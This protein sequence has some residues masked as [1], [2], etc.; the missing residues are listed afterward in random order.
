MNDI[1]IIKEIDVISV[2][3]EYIVLPKE[4]AKELEKALKEYLTKEYGME[5]I[6][7]EKL[8]QIG[9]RTDNGHGGWFKV[10]VKEWGK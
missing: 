9:L 8:L 4:I 1:E 2:E 3:N 5:Y 7:T 6:T 10:K